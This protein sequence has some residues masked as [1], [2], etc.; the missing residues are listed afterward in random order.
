MSL[1][2]NA[3]MYI[4]T[5]SI[6]VNTGEVKISEHKL[7][8]SFVHTCSVLAF[9]VNNLNFLAHIDAFEPN[10]KE[11]IL[12]ELNNVNLKEINEIHVWKG[13]NCLNN[14]PS[15]NILKDIIQIIGTKNII[16]HQIN[17]TN[18]IFP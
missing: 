16:Y 4:T 17:E 5:N 9:S 3:Y 11:K 13:K 18:I 7:S 15:F 2:C 14:C 12:K 6:C 1:L 10:M 8:T